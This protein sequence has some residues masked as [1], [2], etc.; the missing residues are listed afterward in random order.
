MSSQRLDA[1]L[2][3]DPLCNDPK[4]VRCKDTDEDGLRARMLIDMI[5][6][7]HDGVCRFPKPSKGDYVVVKVTG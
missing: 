1:P 5:E 3:R 2:L 4:N 6:E 7:T